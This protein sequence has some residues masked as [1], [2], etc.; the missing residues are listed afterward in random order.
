[1][2]R[3]RT[4]QTAVLAYLAV[5]VF[6]LLG[7]SLL[8]QSFST[9]RHSQREQLQDEVFYAAEGG[10]EDAIGRFGQAIA[11]FQVDT[12][13]TRYPVVGSLVTAFASGATASSVVEQAE[14]T[15]RTVADPDGISIFLKNYHITTTVAH[16][17]FPGVTATVHQVVERRI[18][19]TFQ[20]A[21]FYDGDLEWLPGPDMTLSGRV[22]S[23]G[24]IYIGTNALL[25]VD[26]EYL[27][28]T[29]NIFNRR[30]DSSDSM[31]GIVQIKKADTSPPQY[32]AMAGLDSANPTW[33]TQSQTRWNGTVKT[34][35][36]GVTK[37]AVPVVGS[38]APGG[39]Y[40]TNAQMRIVN[41]TVTL[42]GV[43]LVEGVNL[44]PGTVT[45]STTFYNNRE[46]KFVKMSNV[47]LKKLAG[48]FDVNGDSVLDPP[49]TPGNPYTNQL[50][51]N[52]LI[53]ATRT[54]A[55]GS[56][57][58][59]VR[60]LNGSEVRRT[61]GLTIVSNDPMYIQGN[62]NTTSKKPVA[63]VA[64]A[65][66][67]LS[68]HWNDSQSTSNNVNSGSPR[69]AT[70]TTFNAAFIAGIKPTVTGNYNGG[71]ENYPRFHERWTGVN[72]SVTGSFVS[73]WN[74]QLAAGN[75]VYGQQASN[76]QYTAPNRLWTYDASF[77]DGTTLPPFTPWAVE[78]V[79]GAWWED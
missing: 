41:N 24:D 46:G 6:T 63:V 38:I 77:S 74:S 47:D 14:P 55:T 4:G 16:P 35:V 33:E 32:L 26:S 27:R 76:S 49:G 3:S 1:M 22:H 30:K 17:A 52:G 11:N 51:A 15:P 58:P 79:K 64:D 67:L 69:T 31:P 37:R 50:P 28:A 42:N 71:L 65:M 43:A 29:G 21:V 72:C 66:N 9:Q 5:A 7:G 62:F 10:I 57:Q 8:S 34:G 48:Y 78:I 75:W 56:Q 2:L 68:N 39:F 54:D 45:A 40:D 59:G 44:P 19:Y 70:A 18:I 12:N 61:G 20:H 13:I 36:H 23:N 53:Y 60:L 73:L 25:T